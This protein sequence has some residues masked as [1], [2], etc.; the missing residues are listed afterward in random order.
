MDRDDEL[1]HLDRDGKARMVD[2]GD[3]SETSRSARA[4]ATLRMKPTTRRTL[5]DG[6]APKG[7]VM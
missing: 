7:D 2:V 3:K 1:T 6:T 5:L 4:R